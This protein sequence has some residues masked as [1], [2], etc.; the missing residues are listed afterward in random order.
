[1]LFRQRDVTSFPWR[2][3]GAVDPVSTIAGD[4]TVVVEI[5]ILDSKRVAI[6]ATSVRCRRFR[7]FGRYRCGSVAIDE[8]ER[9]DQPLS[10]PRPRR[11][12]TYRDRLGRLRL[13]T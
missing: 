8:E 2:K 1:M 10:R 3:S 6:R 4:D 13:S 11:S 5:E 9:K 7:N 12:R